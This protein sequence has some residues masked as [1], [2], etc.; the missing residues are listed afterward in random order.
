MADAKFVCHNCD[1]TNKD[2]LNVALALTKCH[3]C[4][5]ITWCTLTK[6]GRHE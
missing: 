3:W 2:W 6:G 1:Q 4:G 5:R